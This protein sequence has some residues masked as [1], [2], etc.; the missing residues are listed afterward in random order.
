V[1]KLSE[2]EQGYMEK[3]RQRQKEGIVKKQIVQGKEFKGQAFISKPEKIEFKVGLNAN[4]RV[5]R[6][7]Q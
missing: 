7:S 5:F 3:A 4:L 2:L 6:T 1:P